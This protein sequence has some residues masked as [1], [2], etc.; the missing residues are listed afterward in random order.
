MKVSHRV[1]PTGY[2]LVV[3]GLGA[4][5]QVLVVLF[6]VLIFIYITIRPLNSVSRQHIV[7]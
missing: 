4:W 5:R 7:T 3:L 2:W 6:K 1:G